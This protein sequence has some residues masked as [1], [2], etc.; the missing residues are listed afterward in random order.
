MKN[1]KTWVM[2]LTAATALLWSVQSCDRIRETKETI[3][4]AEDFA[5]SETEFA[6]AFDIAD[7][8]S[9]QDSRLRS[10]ANSILPSGAI[11]TF[12]DSSFTD[13]DGVEYEIDFGPLGA[14]APFGR[15]C[16]DGRYRAGK[17]RVTLDRRYSEIGAIGTI[18]I[19]EGYDYHSGD[20]LIMT[21]ISGQVTATRLE[22]YKLNVQVS[23][24]KAVRSGKTWRFQGNK[25]VENTN[26]GG[27]GLLGDEF[28]VTGTGSGTNKDGVNYTWT[29]TEPLI[30]RIEVGCA[31]TFIKGII[32]LVNDGG[33]TITVDFDP[34]KDAACDRLARATINGKTFD[35][36]VK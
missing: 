3:S 19:Q 36:T 31:N 4:S 28:K 35:F 6:G 23:N 29:I 8:V 18:D 30:K 9:S 32:S 22:E 26:P 25:V 5:N 20:G 15:L 13:G 7:D 14:S 34:K 16:G 11:L 27:P 24:G 17:F 2:L 21:Q 10:N 1:L 33:G 12:I